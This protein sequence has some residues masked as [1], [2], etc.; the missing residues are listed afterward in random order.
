MKKI[1]LIF[2]VATLSLCA[3]AQNI[4]IGVFQEAFKPIIE[5][6]THGY[7]VKSTAFNL[8]GS[9]KVEFI[10]DEELGKTSLRIVYECAGRD[11]AKRLKDHLALHIE[12]TLPKGDFKKVTGYG[13]QYFDYLKYTF[14]YNTE[15][16]AETKK[17]PTIE[18]GALKVGDSYV[19]E[20]LI[21]EPYF[22]DQY[23]PV[24]N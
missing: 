13:A 10:V 19:V 20:V 4:E 15:V 23:T 1:L 17:R 7:D 8:P 12:T 14:E 18:I 22:R 24:W 9:S 6:S 16:Y 11:E 2:T 5:A 3:H 21:S